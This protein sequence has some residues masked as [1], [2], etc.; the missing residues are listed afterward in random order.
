MF[1][2]KVLYHFDGDSFVVRSHT[3]FPD[4]GLKYIDLNIRLAFVDAPERMQPGGHESYL[5]LVSLIPTGSMVVVV[6]VEQDKYL[7]FI[8]MIRSESGRFINQEMLESGQCVLN[9]KFLNAIAFEPLALELE[10][11][12]SYAKRTRLGFWSI[13]NRVMP[14]EWRSMYPSNRTVEN[15]W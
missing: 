11:A 13:P 14:W 10:G 1:S 8:S 3:A 9:R 6:P 15:R 5:H 4:S 12:E 2:A 7:R